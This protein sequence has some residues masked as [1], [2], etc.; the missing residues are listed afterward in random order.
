ML[1]AVAA[2]EALAGL[3]CAIKSVGAVD[4][5]PFRMCRVGDFGD[6]AEGRCEGLGDGLSFG[7]M[8]LLGFSQERRTS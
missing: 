1:D 2:V 3:Y 7:G 4:L 6:G 5:G 8:G